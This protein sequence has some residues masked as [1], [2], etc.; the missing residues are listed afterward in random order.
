MPVSLGSWG[1]KSPLAHHVY[2]TYPRRR[3][4]RG[5]LLALVLV[6]IV[7]VVLIAAGSLRSDTRALVAYLEEARAVALEHADQSSDFKDQVFTNLQTLDRDR[8][9]TLMTKMTETA[10]SASVRLESIEVP[11]AGAGAAAA[12]SLAAS[13]W[14]TGLAGFEGALLEVVDNPDSAVAVGQLAGCL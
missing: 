7:A 14:E 13:S 2:A 9:M 11:P 12:L 3:R 10:G 6:S 1:F 4:R 5:A 8:L